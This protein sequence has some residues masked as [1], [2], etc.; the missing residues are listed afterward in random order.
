MRILVHLTADAEMEY[1]NSYHHHLRG[2]LWKSLKGTQYSG[3][4]DEIFAPGFCFSNPFPP[5]EIID[6]GSHKML[7]I[8]ATTMDVLAHIS[9]DLLDD[10]QL[11]VGQM[12]FIV[13]D[14]HEAEHEIGEPGTKGTLKTDTE[15]FVSFSQKEC[16]NYN[17][18]HPGTD[19]R[20]FWRPKHGIEPFKN[21]L[22][23][24]LQRNHDRYGR[25]D[26]PGP[27]EVDHNLFTGYE[28]LDSYGVPL[29]VSSDTTL[30]IIVS[31]WKLHYEVQNEWHREHLNLALDCGIGT[32]TGMG[33]GFLNI[34]DKQLPGE[35]R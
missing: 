27:A 5:E 21:K 31:K 26:I 17:I 23:E 24:N 22:I 18:S 29:Q 2:R 8:S 9:A 15:I 7:L 4:H 3:R 20:T 35:H 33:L 16:E 28:Y 1:D 6:E 12:P 32:K 14:I 30:D 13:D 34:K 25:D 19:T 11:Q 10:R